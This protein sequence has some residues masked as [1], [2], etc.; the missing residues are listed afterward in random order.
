MPR[1][2]IAESAAKFDRIRRAHQSE[3][4]EDYVEMIADLIAETGEARTVDLAAR[5]GVT[6]PTVNAIIQRLQ[7]E[8][9][10]ETR[11]Y[12]S[13]FLT[14][15]GHALAK[16]ARARHRVVRDFLV[17]IG[18]PETIAEEDAEGIEHHVSAE[19]LAVFAKITN[20]D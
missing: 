6:S 19:T 18:V 15:A 4:A 12:R 11:P 16:E 9:L 14:D 2:A 20:Q 13:I 17:A 3:V 5:F 8:D 10:V 1:K 7:R